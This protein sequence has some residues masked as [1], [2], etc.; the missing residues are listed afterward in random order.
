VGGGKKII[1][2]KYDSYRWNI[3]DVLDPKSGFWKHVCKDIKG[4]FYS[5][6]DDER[7]DLNIEPFSNRITKFIECFDNLSSKN[8]KLVH[9]DIVETESLITEVLW[10]LVHLQDKEIL[11]HNNIEYFSDWIDTCP[12]VLLDMYIHKL[13][14]GEKLTNHIPK[15]KPI[16][17]RTIHE[18]IRKSI[19]NNNSCNVSIFNGKLILSSTNHDILKKFKKIIIK[20]G[21]I[22]YEYREDK[23]E[24]DTTIH[25]YI[26]E[27]NTDEAKND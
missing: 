22:E 26:F 16:Q 10:D 8:K 7:E 21:N 27:M 25:A 9:D 14:K 18:A 23:T 24:T 1:M 4:Y 12:Q 19:F 20:S 6:E 13:S 5:L 15:K 2:K 11:F 3:D 17:S